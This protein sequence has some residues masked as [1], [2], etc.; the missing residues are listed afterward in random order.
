MTFI[1]NC[2]TS[3]LFSSMKLKYILI[4]KLFLAFSN[5]LVATDDLE[6]SNFS[7]NITKSLKTP[8]G[9]KLSISESIGNWQDNKGNY[10]KSRLIFYV[11][12]HNKVTKI[13]GYGE[14]MDQENNK[15]WILAERESY[16]EAGV[17]K[18]EII[19]ADKKY[20]H[21]L[22]L[23]CVYAVK[24]LDDRSFLKAKCK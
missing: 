13:K 22:K 18:L 3:Y 2:I 24:Y 15:I 20:K 10:G 9:S 4:I 14:L 7:N 6:I 12:E 19:D 21:L 16:Q 23:K 8:N 11:E 1:K 5:L 17:G